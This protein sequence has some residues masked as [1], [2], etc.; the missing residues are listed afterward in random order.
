MVIHALVGPASIN[1]NRKMSQCQW[2]AQRAE[3]TGLG[4]AM[5]AS[6]A[7]NAVFFGGA[8]LEG[9]GWRAAATR[10]CPVWSH[11]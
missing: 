9:A 7:M 11:I 3:G 2:M 6:D 8:D 1:I 4:G 10:E 5:N